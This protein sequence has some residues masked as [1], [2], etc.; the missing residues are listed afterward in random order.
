M[1]SRADRSVCLQECEFADLL[2]DGVVV[3][4]EARQ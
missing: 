4:I 3:I 1:I 2:K